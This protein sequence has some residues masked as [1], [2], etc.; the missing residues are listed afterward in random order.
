MIETIYRQYVYQ[1]EKYGV[2]PTRLVLGIEVVRDAIKQLPCCSQYRQI[3]IDDLNGKVFLFGTPIT[4]DMENPRL[5][6]IS[7]GE[8]YT[9]EKGRVE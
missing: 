2:A 8:D 9:L 6:N 4:V 5:I 7:I 1:Y 3:K